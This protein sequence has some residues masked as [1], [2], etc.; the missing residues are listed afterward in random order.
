MKIFQP[1]SVNRQVRISYACKAMRLTKAHADEWNRSRPQPFG[2]PSCC[3]SK[4]N[5]RMT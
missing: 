2:K 5:L 3:T 1:Y 4:L